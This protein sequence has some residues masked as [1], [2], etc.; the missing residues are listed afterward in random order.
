M[1]I[2]VDSINIVCS[3]VCIL[4]ELSLVVCL[5]WDAITSH[6]YHLTWHSEGMKAVVGS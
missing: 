2:S 3:Y 6:S 4:L 1:T 5:A